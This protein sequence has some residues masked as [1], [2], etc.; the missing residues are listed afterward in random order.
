MRIAAAIIVLLAHVVQVH[1]LRFGLNTLL[2]KISSI[3]SEYAVAGF[4][5][6]SGYLITHSLEM[7]IQRNGKLRLHI[8]FASRIAR[9]CTD[10]YLAALAISNGWRLVSF[11]DRE[12]ERCGDLQRLSLS[13]GG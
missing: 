1:F 9:L 6:L 8:Y 7:N 5:I 11:F 2:H 13:S 12:F 4:F 3:A 10:A